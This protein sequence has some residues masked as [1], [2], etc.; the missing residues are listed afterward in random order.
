MIQ[1]LKIEFHIITDNIPTAT[2]ILLEESVGI[3][4]SVGVTADARHISV[5]RTQTLGL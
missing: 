1:R 2:S 5:F 4:I 3:K